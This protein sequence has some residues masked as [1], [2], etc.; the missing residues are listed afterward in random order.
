[1]YQWVGRPYNPLLLERMGEYCTGM[2]A[3]QLSLISPY[4]PY[5]RRLSF[6]IIHSLSFAAHEHTVAH[7]FT[8]LL[9]SISSCHPTSPYTTTAPH[10]ITWCVAVT[11]PQKQQCDKCRAMLWISSIKHGNWR[12]QSSCLFISLPGCRVSLFL[13]LPP[14]FSVPLLLFCHH[15]ESVWSLCCRHSVLY[16]SPLELSGLHRWQTRLHFNERHCWLS[17]RVKSDLMSP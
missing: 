10:A 13:S 14:I 8:A 1:M 5:C 17:E 16:G 15:V 6:F 9:L 4:F 2:L 12:H 3:V 11:A 7:S